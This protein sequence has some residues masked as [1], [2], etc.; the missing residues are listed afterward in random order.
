MEQRY[1]IFGIDKEFINELLYRAYSYVDSGFCGKDEWA[2]K[3][4]PYFYMYETFNLNDSEIRYLIDFIWNIKY[5]V[6]GKSH[7]IAEWASI[8]KETRRQEEMRNSIDRLFYA[9]E[10]FRSSDF[11]L[12]LLRFAAKFKLLAPYNTM[13]VR[14][15]MPSA[16]YVLTKNQ[17][18]KMYGRR[19]KRNARPLV[20]LRK[21]GPIDYVFEISD[22]EPMPNVLFPKT[23]DEI[24]ESLADPY[25]TTGTINLSLYENLVNALAYY[26][27]E[28]DTFRVAA[29]FGAEIRKTPC[30]VKVNGVEAQGH[31][32]ISVNDKANR[33]S[34][35][36][37]ICHELGHFFCRHLIAPKKGNGNWWLWRKLPWE[38]EEFEAEIVSYIICERYG[39]GSKSWEYL[40]QVV[41]RTGKIPDGISI[42]RVFKA[43]NEVERLL[44][45]DLDPRTCYLYQND[46]DFKKRYDSIHPKMLSSNRD[47][48]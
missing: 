47:D 43:A 7:T 6:N 41:G 13:M 40:S 32:V 35:F 48:E 45:S 3:I 46:S 33:G 12:S 15:Q 10:D 28:L 24:L 9:I 39:V 31:Y 23:I 11:F 8:K 1:E 22:T 27:I 44:K 20:V 38:L 36:A 17:W 30:K 14:T 26:G 4:T 42:D 16:R 34:S 25:A 19:P 5:T 21:F 2:Q 18:E 29:S 37:S